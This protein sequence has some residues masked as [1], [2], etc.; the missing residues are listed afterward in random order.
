MKMEDKTIQKYVD[1]Y[2]EI[3]NKIKEMLDKLERCGLECNCKDDDI[4]YIKL[5]HNG[6]FEDEIHTFCL[7]CGGIKS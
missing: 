6:L 7:K 4:D 1:E 5:I 3:Q 2:F